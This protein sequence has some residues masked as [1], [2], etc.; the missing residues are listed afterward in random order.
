MQ[1]GSNVLI[2]G[3][4][5]TGTQP[6]K[7]ILRAVAPSLT[8]QGVPVPG[9]LADTTLEL[10]GS[11]GPIATNDNWRTGGQE[12]EI[13][14]ST[15]PPTNDLESA[16]VATLPANGSGY[17]AIVTEGQGMPPALVWWKFSTWMVQRLIPS[18]RTFQLAA[19]CKRETI[20]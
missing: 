12:A 5:V 9:R 13:I 7:V 6:K 19:S 4:I 15:V 8:V 1:T 14:A 2:G 18:W 16:L 10:V 20:S 17:T 3:F 11:S